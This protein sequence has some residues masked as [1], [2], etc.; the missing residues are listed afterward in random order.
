LVV[1]RSLLVE[2][3]ERTTMNYEPVGG[4]GA[5]SV[6]VVSVFAVSVGGG[7][8]VAVVSVGG[9]ACVA[10]V[11]VGGGCGLG[12]GCAVALDIGGGCVAVVGRYAGGYA[13]NVPATVFGGC[14]PS[15]AG[16][17]GSVKFVVVSAAVFVIGGGVSPGPLIV[18][19]TP[20]ACPSSTTW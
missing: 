13:G 19:V 17:S 3:D 18:D 5:V 11:S 6:F 20:L 7:A 9:G 12:F 14:V 15:G 2:H 1:G 4:G 16:L 8:S 10:I